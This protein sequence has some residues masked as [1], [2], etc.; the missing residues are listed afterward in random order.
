MV[1]WR[2]TMWMF[3]VRQLL[4]EHHGEEHTSNREHECV[5]GDGQELN[6]HVAKQRPQGAC[7]AKR[8]TH[9]H[10]NADSSVPPIL[11]VARIGSCPKISRLPP[12]TAA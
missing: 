5:A 4:D 7:K 1:L 9:E 10:A 12:G 2:I 8:P 3:H 11:Y 6:A